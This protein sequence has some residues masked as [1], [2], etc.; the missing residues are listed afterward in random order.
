MAYPP[1]PHHPQDPWG[2]QAQEPP[3]EHGRSGYGRPSSG[4]ASPPPG[5]GPPGTG[6][7]QN[8]G[9]PGPG[10]Q[11]RQGGPP[12]P[13]NPLDWPTQYGKGD[14]YGL[15]TDR[16]GLPQD[17]YGVPS[18][19]HGLPQDSYGLPPDHHGLPQD[20]YGVPS[21][22]HGI[23]QDPYG[24]PQDLYDYGRPPKRNSALIIALS[25]G[26]GVLL[27]GGGTIGAVTYVK[28]SASERGTALP[29]GA[30][31]LPTT[32]PWQSDS[33]A[34]DPT[35]DPSDPT[36]DPGDPTADPAEPGTE[37]TGS[38]PTSSRAQPGSPI[39]HTE[40]DDWKFALSGVKFDANKVAGWTYDTCDPVD[41]QGVLAKNKCE[42]AVQVAY[43]AYR[44]HLKAVQVMMA[45]PTDKAARTAATRLAKVPADSVNIRRDMA[46]A[47]FSYGKI[48]T[49]VSKKYVVVTIVTADKT[50][51]SKADKFHLY[52]Q[53]DAVSYFLLRDLTITS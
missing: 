13:P 3:Q 47:N 39:A 18:G 12:P 51:R 41:A 25:V 52:M 53:A 27:L 38:P 23:P 1:Q 15:P 49:N 5:Y 48:R 19:R 8:P 43:S 32:A 22:R 31:S 10:P 35:T 4:Q 33:P 34:A 7:P 37:P 40:F 16:H 26:L 46:L 11:P 6:R 20:S 28:S 29:S 2:Q 50:A 9:R 42:R 44:G 21:D 30:T 36:T 14:P 17:S 24:L 45:F